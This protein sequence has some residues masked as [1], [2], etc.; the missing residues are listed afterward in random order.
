MKKE[1][2]PINV[3][4]FKIEST[5]EDINKKV[6]CSKRKASIIGVIG[7]SDFNVRYF[8]SIIKYIFQPFDLMDTTDDRG[9]FRDST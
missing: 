6:F 4:P 8:N 9:V 7:I 1:V 3:S 2:E 5:P